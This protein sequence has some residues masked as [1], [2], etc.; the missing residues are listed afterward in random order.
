MLNNSIL[1]QIDKI[2][3]CTALTKRIKIAKLKLELI[4]TLEQL[5]KFNYLNN[6]RN[7][8]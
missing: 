1:K 7:K 8:K 5:S 3:S 4:P 6:K 2:N